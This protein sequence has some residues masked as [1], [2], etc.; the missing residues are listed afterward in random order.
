MELILK[1]HIFSQCAGD[2]IWELDF[3]RSPDS[4]VQSTAFSRICQ[5]KLLVFQSI[6]YLC[7]LLPFFFPFPNLNP[8]VWSPVTLRVMDPI[9]LYLHP[10]QH[11]IILLEFNT[12][13]ILDIPRDGFHKNMFSSFSTIIFKVVLRAIFFKL[14]VSISNG[15]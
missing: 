14:Q 3:F 12:F 10:L 8:Q 13:K 4:G 6:S 7:L 5:M 11:H 9:S 2:I 1:G 15:S